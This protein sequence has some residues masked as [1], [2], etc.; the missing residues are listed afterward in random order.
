MRN[1]P[2][3]LPL[4][5]KLERMIEYNHRWGEPALTNDQ[6]AAGLTERLGRTVEPA[7]IES[8]RSGAVLVI[9]RDIAEALCALCGVTDVGI[10]LPNGD[11]DVDLDLRVQL[12]T[13][14]R[15]RGVQHVAARAM[16]R[17]KLRELIADL[18]AL[19]PR[20]A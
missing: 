15:D 6:I 2:M 8:L 5:E 7:Y 4:A 3:S 20:T 14:V 1:Y 12:W 10:L 13:L 16:T 9:P 17:D 19:P 11:E 18:Q